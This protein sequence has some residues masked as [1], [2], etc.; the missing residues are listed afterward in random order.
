MKNEEKKIEE[1][2]ALIPPRILPWLIAGAFF[3]QMLDGTILN[4]ALPSIAHS[5]GESPLQIQGIV[6]AYFLTVAFL[7]P[8]SGWLADRF[9]SK[10]IFSIAIVLFVL[11]STFCALSNTLLQLTL[12]RVFQ[13]IGGAMMVPVGRLI[14]LKVYPKKELIRM[15]SFIML[16][17]LLGPLIGPVVGGFLVEYLSWHWIFLI[18]IPI[19]LICLGLTWWKMPEVGKNEIYPFDWLG[20]F[21]F[22]VAILLVS[23][24][25]NDNQLMDVQG[26]H[27][28]YYLA[29]A[30]ILIVYFWYHAKRA[31]HPLFHP[32]LFKI[33]SFVVGALGSIFSRIGV[34]GLP[35]L[36]PL[37]MQVGLGFSPSKSGM[38]VLTLGIAAIIAKQLVE[39]VLKLFGYRKFL[40]ANTIFIGCLMC[41]FAL[42]TT[43]T[44]DWALVLLLFAIGS[45]N[46]LQ[47]TAM[48]TLALIDLPNSRASEGNSLVSVVMQI[49]MSIGVGVTAL[50]LCSFAPSLTHEPE[51]MSGFHKTYMVMGLFTILSSVNFLFVK[52]NAG[53]LSK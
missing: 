45:V 21:A 2:L 35:Y 1:D 13:A 41:C 3:M 24:V 18:N 26:Y 23:I 29:V 43:A 46:S 9:G 16:P 19:G 42:I 31:K 15:L 17:A 11:G 6:V 39:P 5:I 25:A 10:H 37:L 44:P 53:E 22:S 40:F 27:K 20:F 33:R 30:L 48:A 8:L 4:T 49:S 52:K 32:D 50:L 38:M 12:S 14:V 47:F 34:G 28:L 36:A 51:V 7:L